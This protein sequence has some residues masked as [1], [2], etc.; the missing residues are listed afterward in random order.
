MESFNGCKE[1]YLSVLK[2]FL[3]SQ[4]AY[5]IYFLYKHFVTCSNILCKYSHAL[6]NATLYYHLRE[7]MLPQEKIWRWLR[8]QMAFLSW[9]V[10]SVSIWTGFKQWIAVW[11]TSKCLR[12]T[13]L[14]KDESAHSVAPLSKDTH[15]QVIILQNFNQGISQIG[16]LHSFLYTVD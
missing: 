6:F 10:F 9:D 16:N 4:T 2:N 5:N 7:N 8:N 15:L 1:N 11:Q 12:N 13:Y 3:F 14:E